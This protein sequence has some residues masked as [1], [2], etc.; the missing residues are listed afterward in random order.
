MTQGFLNFADMFDG[1]GVGRSGQT[2]EG[3]PFSGLLNALGVRPYGFDERQAEARPM[4]RPMGLLTPPD[5][6]EPVATQ[7]MIGSLTPDQI[8]AAI[9][10][11][12]TSMPTLQEMLQM[13]A[14]RRAGYYPGGF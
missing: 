7:P 10:R 2:F 1:G 3:G 9:N 6:P 11:A 5:Q 4:R 12:P 8:L 13:D 14:M